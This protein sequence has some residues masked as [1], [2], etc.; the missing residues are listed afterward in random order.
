L[1]PRNQNIS[2]LQSIRREWP[3][4]SSESAVNSAL[5]LAFG[6]KGELVVLCHKHAVE[7]VRRAERDI[8]ARLE[9]ALERPVASEIVVLAGDVALGALASVVNDLPERVLDLEDWP[10]R[11]YIRASVSLGLPDSR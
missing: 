5:P 8:L 10:I 9:A 3:N 4:V 7:I 6:P 11:T 1:L 2:A